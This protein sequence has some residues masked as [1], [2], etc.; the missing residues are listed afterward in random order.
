MAGQDV[1][2]AEGI[3]EG[4]G[5]GVAGVVLV[6]TFHFVEGGVHESV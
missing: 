6:E 4:E 1:P 2:D 5:G 3:V